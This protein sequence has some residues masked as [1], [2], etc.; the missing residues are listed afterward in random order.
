MSDEY[1]KLRI[2]RLVPSIGP[3]SAA[4]NQFTL[5]LA[6]KQSITLC[7]YFRPRISVPGSIKLFSGDNS[8][9][10]F[11]SA[12][13]KALRSGTFDV[14]HTHSPH[15]AFL[16]MFYPQA[17]FGPTLHT[18]HSSYPHYKPRNR[19][20]LFPV[21]ASFRK[22]VF[23]SNASQM[24]FPRLLT[25]LLNS[26]GAIIQNGVDLDRIDR[27]ISEAPKSTDNL[28]PTIIVV[29][30]LIELKNPLSALRAFH[31]SGVHSN[32]RLV[33]IGEG[34]LRNELAVECRQ[35]GLDDRVTFTGLIPRNE[36]FRHMA[37]ARF[38]VSASS[39]E[40]LPIAVMEAMACRCPVILSDIQP[41][42]EIANGA[43]FI[44]L[45]KH[46]DLDRLAW[47]MHT[48]SCLTLTEKHTTGNSCRELVTE[49]FSLARTHQQYEALYR[50]IAGS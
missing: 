36:V 20:M 10:G 40:G 35:L 48:F 21:I 22:V 27:V 3:T 24:S 39:I 33:F 4:Y 26:R 38:F 29:G 25:R 49:R 7:V 8:L 43:N 2:L 37:Q 15:V 41:H 6:D 14:I 11:F 28:E 23:C 19:L 13:G 46:D 47:L 9:P 1:D 50:E 45:F 12:L 32:M 17:T 16:S 30:R 42:R 44:P 31:A 34:P 5:P 18:V